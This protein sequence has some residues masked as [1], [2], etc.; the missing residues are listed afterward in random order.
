MF[1]YVRRIFMNDAI[2]EAEELL[3]SSRGE[4]PINSVEMLLRGLLTLEIAKHKANNKNE[5]PKP[6]AKRSGKKS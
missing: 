5:V 4:F 1:I 3:Q 2:K 6:K